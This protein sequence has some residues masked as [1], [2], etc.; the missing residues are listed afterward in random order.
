MT[1]PY[2][3]VLLKLSGE[4]LEG[5]GGLSIDPRVLSG[6]A[7]EISA[8]LK[9]GSQVAVVIGGGNL[10]RGMTMAAAGM[11]RTAAD[12]M[13]MLATVMNCVAMQDALVR[14]GIRASILSAIPVMQV[15]DPFTRREA[16]HRL[17]DGEVV[18]LGGGTGNPY[19]TTDT[20]AA[21]RALEVGADVLLKATKVDGIY[22]KDPKKHADAV[23]FEEISYR[24]VLERRLQVM[25]LTA[26]TLCRDNGLPMVVFDM[27]AEGNIRRVI[28]GEPVGSR[29]VEQRS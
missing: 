11:D 4:A 3:R 24:E 18:L 6:I 21:L 28:S 7:Q 2:R 14:E 1:T 10:F 17:E 5:G 12:T 9:R 19:F 16:V 27:T 20:A 8:V 22:D 15:C 29:V 25:D 23:R 26:V 13:G